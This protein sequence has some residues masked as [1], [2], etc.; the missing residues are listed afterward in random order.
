MIDQTVE[1]LAKEF[2]QKINR[3][4]PPSF[5]YALDETIFSL[6]ILD[7][8][9]D[10]RLYCASK[11]EKLRD[12]LLA[13]AY[14]GICLYKIFKSF[15]DKVKLTFSS[16]GSVKII[17]K[18]SE[19]PYI[20]KE[21]V[22]INIVDIFLHTAI[23][24]PDR[25]SYIKEERLPMGMTYKRFSYAIAGI[26]SGMHPLITGPWKNLSEEQLSPYLTY[27]CRT[28][29]EQT[30][31]V[32]LSRLPGLQDIL[33][34]EVFFPYLVFPPIG[35][36]EDLYGARAGIAIAHTF[37][38]MKNSTQ[39]IKHLSSILLESPHPI[40]FS[41]GFIF[42]AALEIK[43]ESKSLY[44][45]SELCPLLA[46]KLY[47]AI[48]L[49]RSHYERPQN[50]HDL[51]KDERYEEANL[52]L[53][54]D[55]EIGLFPLLLCPDHSLTINPRYRLYF[56]SICSFLLKEAHH[57]GRIFY[58]AI[59]TPVSIRIQHAFIC[60]SVGE[61]DEC[62]DILKDL[63]EMKRTSLE[64]IHSNFLESLV[65]GQ[66]SEN[67][68]FALDSLAKIKNPQVRKKLLAQEFTS[69]QSSE[70]K[71]KLLDDNAMFLDSY[72]IFERILLGLDEH[73]TITKS[74]LINN[75]KRITSSPYY[76]YSKDMSETN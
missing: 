73:N 71:K 9:F 34:P 8:Y 57:I 63:N 64:K 42:A 72:L 59:E 48:Q 25:I 1:D 13:S 3:L 27:L 16:S 33:G 6:N 2:A 62:R 50:W 39:S 11:E 26:L 4:A 46:S 69:L 70:G 12:L 38:A 31:I 41:I 49:I 47:P 61:L 76:F 35:Y 65:S 75:F 56:E 29:S 18:I 22:S 66:H 7:L 74:G 40:H 67:G 58:Q 5:A 21:P 20:F 60:L 24:P 23:E 17:L 14:T 15:T 43:K 30:S 55:T 52:L 36:L 51:A 32:L 28:L 45:L 44:L 37:K 19:G 53:D 54:H 68:H 10:E